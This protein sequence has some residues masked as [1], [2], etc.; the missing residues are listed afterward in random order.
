MYA[1]LFPVSDYFSVNFFL[2][3][4]QSKFGAFIV[5]TTIGIGL[6]IQLC[7]VSMGVTTL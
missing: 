5:S 6:Y 1:L 7:Q 2:L 4:V 3:D